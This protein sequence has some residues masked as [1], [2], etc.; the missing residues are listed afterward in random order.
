MY[1]RLSKVMDECGDDSLEI[2][3]REFERGFYLYWEI[4]R[5]IKYV[6]S[7]RAGDLKTNL[8]VFALCFE[9]NIFSL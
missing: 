9:D 4:K 8:M 5:L 1:D 3:E 2:E 6:K 7:K